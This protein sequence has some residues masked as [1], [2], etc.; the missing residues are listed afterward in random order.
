MESS[1]WQERST[2]CG[3]TGGP[4]LLAVSASQGRPPIRSNSVLTIRTVFDRVERS[5]FNAH[6][7]FAR[8]LT[9]HS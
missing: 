2:H 7:P 4:T 6:Y 5:A 3:A 9:V 8:Y 1:R